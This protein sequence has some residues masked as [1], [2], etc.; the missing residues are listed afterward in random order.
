MYISTLLSDTQKG[1]LDKLSA[2]VDQEYVKFLTAQVPDAFNE[3][4]EIFMQY[5]A[6]ILGYFQ[7]KMASVILTRFV[8]V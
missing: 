6:T 3:R 5:G 8:S 2:A 7:D 4:L 1:T